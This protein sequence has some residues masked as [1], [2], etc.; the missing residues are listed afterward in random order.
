MTSTI[1][2]F[3]VRTA[4]SGPCVYCYV[5]TFFA[6]AFRSKCV[7]INLY[8]MIF[9]YSSKC[10]SFFR[11]CVRALSC[12]QK[13]HNCRQRCGNCCTDSKLRDCASEQ[14]LRERIDYALKTE[15][16]LDKTQLSFCSKLHVRRF[17]R[18]KYSSPMSL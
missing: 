9:Q 10:V 11:C 17:G 7:P 5:H 1:A 13:N 12:R 15:F 14:H 8:Y 3:T 2:L 6:V 18:S 16:L 4:S